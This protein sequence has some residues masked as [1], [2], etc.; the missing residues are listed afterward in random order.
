MIGQEGLSIELASLAYMKTKPQVIT[1]L[2]DFGLQDEYVGVMKGVILSINSSIQLVDLTHDIS[3]H[4]IVQAAL[5]IKC[6]FRHFPKGSIHIIVVDPG[7]GGD[8]KVICLKKEG[9]FF[10][11]P[12]NGS[13][14][15]V[16]QDGKVNDIRDVTNEAYFLRPVSNT[17]HGRDILAPVAAHL[18]KGVDIGRL[19]QKIKPS[20]V[21]ALDIAVPFLSP[22]HELVGNIVWIDRFGNLISNIDQ[23]IFDRF[24]RGR[25][26]E[27][28]VIQLGR[29]KINGVSRSY[30]SVKIGSPVALFGSRNLLEISVNQADARTH[31]KASVG[32]TVKIKVPSG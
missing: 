8:R 27:D 7:V 19:G 30:E 11:A 18:S 31:F 9:H 32:K 29:F 21:I 14:S 4:D 17:F 28:V 15:L 23:E 5:V 12:D 3:R 22:K 26:S 6:A 24:C 13:L 1:L 16:I 20:D 10:I 25:R 2:T